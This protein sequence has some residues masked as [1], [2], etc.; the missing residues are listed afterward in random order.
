MRF[1]FASRASLSVSER[2][3]L[4]N[5]KQQLPFPGFPV[6]IVP[7][8]VYELLGETNFLRRRRGRDEGFETTP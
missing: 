3:R 7:K 1:V 6:C 8:N 4:E 2:F 5:A